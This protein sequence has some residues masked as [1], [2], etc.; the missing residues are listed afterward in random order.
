MAGRKQRKIQLTI[1][2]DDSSSYLPEWGIRQALREIIQNAK[3]SEV[4]FNAPMTL[5]WYVGST[6][7]ETLRITNEGCSLSKD[8][9]LFGH[10]TKYG[11]SELIGK[12]GE[13]L[14]LA[15]AV[16]AREGLNVRVFTSND[17]E[18]IGEIWVPEIER[19]ETFNAKV[20]AIT[21]KE[22]QYRKRVRVE[23][24]GLDRNL[25]DQY[26][27]DYLFL[28]G[29]N[30]GKGIQVPSGEILL[31]SMYS[32]K[33]YV[34]GIFVESRN[35]MWGYNFYNAS[36]DRDRKMVDYW[37]YE[38]NRSKI[39]NEAINLERV[40]VYE[41]LGMMEASAEDVKGYYFHDFIDVNSADKLKNQFILKHGNN[42]FPV[43]ND[44]QAIQLAHLDPEAKAIVVPDSLGKI[45]NKAFGSFE[46]K[47]NCLE[48]EIIK[49]YDISG[50]DKKEIKSLAWSVGAINLALNVLGIDKMSLAGI[51]VCDFR[52]PSLQGQFNSKNNQINIMKKALS[53]RNLTLEILVHEV[54]HRF[55]K[56]AEHSHVSAIE[57]I[58][59]TI[60]GELTKHVEVV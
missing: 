50:L 9:L 46:D 45:L 33:I 3:D 1:K 17:E 52:S 10:T 13:G 53:D 7:R 48:N 35:T 28:P 49:T 24:E 38:T 47:K 14:K 57:K 31:D 11:R 8:A 12:F 22:A 2:M 19:S 18:G 41:V 6:G 42:S 30:K 4:E 20:L 16:F 23:I 44:G 5:E 60:M 56:D 25:W 55:G 37:S 15:L 34:K 32:G 43:A 39:I 40:D 27:K 51:T 59:S 54:A 29:T 36:L 58:W 26:S 21:I